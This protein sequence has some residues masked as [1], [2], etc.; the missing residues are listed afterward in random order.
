MSQRPSRREDFEV[1]II[2]ALPLEYDAVALLFDEFWDKDGDTFGRAVGDVNNYTTG[3]IGKHDVVLA[4]LPDMGKT[5]AAGAAASMRS[6]YGAL[7]LVILAG[8]CGG[9]PQNDQD[10]V[11]LGDVV[12]SKTVIQYDF[13]TM[14][15]HGFIRKDT[16]E[17]NLSKHDKNI[18]N[19]LAIFN[20]DS[21]QE[22]LQ[23]KTAYFLKQ[24]QEKAIKHRAKYEYPG[25]AKDKLFESSYRHRHHNSGMCVCSNIHGRKDPACDE[26][27]TS[28]CDDLGCDDEYLVER[29]RQDKAQDPAIYIGAVASGDTVM[30]SGEDR[31]RIVKKERVIAFEMEGAGAWEE[32]PCIVVKGICNYADCHK[33]KIWQHFAAA[34]AASASKAILERYMK[35][36]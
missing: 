7:R 27:L 4:L 22:K 10:E 21:G 6:S 29:S 24:L 5:N 20:T 16:V 9:V 26:A 12:I 8:T 3:R 35:T 11:F 15:P 36:D 14:Y 30:M 34:T 23:Q 31:D 2:C 33:N 32:V 18:R 19:L 25:M 17:D 13:G 28:S 1:A